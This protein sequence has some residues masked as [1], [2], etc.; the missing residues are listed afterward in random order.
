[1]SVSRRVSK[2]AP[3]LLTRNTS[4]TLPMLAFTTAAEKYTQLWTNRG[5]TGAKDKSH[6]SHA[7]LSH[8]PRLLASLRRYMG[9]RSLGKD[10]KSHAV[11]M[12]PTGENEVF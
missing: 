7:P 1:M 12:L 2:R 8:C 6:H 9:P 4:P 11:L 5:I 10:T 3:G